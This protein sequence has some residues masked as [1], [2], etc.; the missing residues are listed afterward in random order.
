MHGAILPPPI[1]TPSCGDAYLS[2]GTNLPFPFIFSVACLPIKTQEK[3]F[4]YSF[5]AP[6]KIGVQ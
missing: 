1:H 4:I 2:T 3:L 5:T 6:R